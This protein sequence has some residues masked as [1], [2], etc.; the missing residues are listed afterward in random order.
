MDEGLEPLSHLNLIVLC[1]T[2][3]D[4]EERYQFMLVQGSCRITPADIGKVCGKRKDISRIDGGS[5]QRE[6][7]VIYQQWKADAKASRGQ[8]ASDIQENRDRFG[9]GDGGARMRMVNKLYTPLKKILFGTGLER[10]GS[11]SGHRRHSSMRT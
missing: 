1:E 2:G 7:E 9:G 5:I 6:C 11:L 3:D 10:S 8:D 4:F